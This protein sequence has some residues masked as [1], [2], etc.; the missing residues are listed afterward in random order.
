MLRP[1]H[2]QRNWHGER[3]PA[4]LSEEG[5]GGMCADVEVW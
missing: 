4:H 3:T 2:S 5:G 1:E